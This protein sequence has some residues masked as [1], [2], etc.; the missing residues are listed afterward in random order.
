MQSLYVDTYP[1]LCGQR[2]RFVL[3]HGW[4][5]D[6]SIWQPFV[7]D[8]QQ[9]GEVIC[10]DLP[11]F[12]R[13]KKCLC[14]YSD[15]SLWAIFRDVLKPGD[16]LVGWSLGGNVAL[17]LAAM[18]PD[19]FDALVLIACNPCFVAREDWS[20]GMPA[21]TYQQFV[22]SFDRN[23][24]L[25]IKRFQALQ[26]QGD[27]EAKSRL[28]SMRAAGLEFELATAASA[29]RM[30]ERD[31]RGAMASCSLPMA[32]VLGADDNLVLRQVSDDLLSDLGRRSNVVADMAHLPNAATEACVIQQL[33]AVLGLA[34]AD[35]AKVD[36]AHS[37]GQA[38]HSYDEVAQLQREVAD[39]L[40]QS[41]PILPADATVVDLGCGTGYSLDLLQ[42]HYS[43]QQIIALDLSEKMLRSPRV[44]VSGAMRVAADAE[45]LPL[46]DNS[47]DYIFSSLALQWCSD[48]GQ[49]FRELAR[50]LKPGGQVH[51]SS[52][53]TGTLRELRAAWW[54]VD[55]AVHVN[56]FL[57]W[58]RVRG[59][60]GLSVLSEQVNSQVMRFSDVMSLMRSLKQL[61]A[62]NVNPGRRDGLT[63]RSALRQLQR[64]YDYYAD[65]S[66]AL[67][68]SYEVVYCRLRK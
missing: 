8:L 66:G 28:Q 29:L 58:W 67:P 6:S 16:V 63:G 31:Q 55:D 53:T 38:A 22:S 60:I 11:G 9:L 34:R 12:G 17:A 41:L 10:I 1:A 56:R 59:D 35:R 49:L 15:E 42:Q 26:C 33:T 14:D 19:Y 43:D 36:V 24:A 51:F 45:H 25:A 27:S 64:A 4:A 3:L 23:A 65:A 30:L 61:G 20:R 5:N 18:H 57:P 44:A 39:Q 50:V 37:F 40:A 68:A 46:A 54:A 7:A 13:N 52:L 48:T 21:D 47:V 62:H 32:I 2:Q